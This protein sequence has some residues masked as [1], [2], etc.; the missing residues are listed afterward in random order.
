MPALNMASHGARMWQ[1][2]AADFTLDPDL[3]NFFHVYA[4][5]VSVQ[6]ERALKRCATKVAK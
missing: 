2:L 4:V 1:E 6:V 5:G 3:G